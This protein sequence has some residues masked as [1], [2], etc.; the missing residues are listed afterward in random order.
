[1][2]CRLGQHRGDGAAGCG[3]QDGVSRADEFAAERGDAGACGDAA[4]YEGVACAD[5]GGFCGFKVVVAFFF[6]VSIVL[7][8]AR[9]RVRGDEVALEKVCPGG[10]GDRTARE[11]GFEG[12]A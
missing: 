1:M 10:D 3:H 8:G 6:V 2:V 11:G 12:A 4:G 5:D 9:S 7:F